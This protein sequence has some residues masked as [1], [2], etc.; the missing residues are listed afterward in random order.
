MLFRPEALLELRGDI[1]LAISSLSVGCRD[2]ALPL[3][4]LKNVY[5]NILYFFLAVSAIDAR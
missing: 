2:I 4:F 1:A 5:V 3:S